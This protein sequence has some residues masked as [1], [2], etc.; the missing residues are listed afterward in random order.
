MTARRNSY[1]HPMTDSASSARVLRLNQKPTR[2]R[3]VVVVTL[4]PVFL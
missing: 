1:I 3:G 4:S 2:P